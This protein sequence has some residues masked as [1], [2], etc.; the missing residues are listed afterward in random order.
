[1]EDNGNIQRLKKMNRIKPLVCIVW[2]RILQIMSTIH[3]TNRLG[4]CVKGFHN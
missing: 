2:H 3:Y 1:M 4:V